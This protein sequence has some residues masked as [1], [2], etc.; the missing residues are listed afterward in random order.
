MVLLLLLGLSPRCRRV[1]WQA[2]GQSTGT[3]RPA[4]SAAT[5]PQTPW[6]DLASAVRLPAHS[7]G[8][9]QRHFYSDVVMSFR[10]AKSLSMAA[11]R[12]RRVTLWIFGIG[13]R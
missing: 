7:R 10:T 8:G 5:S 3:H 6:P 13:H 2:S 9:N 12:N 4:R 1:S 11:F